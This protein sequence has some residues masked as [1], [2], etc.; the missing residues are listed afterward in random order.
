MRLEG[1]GRE[2]WRRVQAASWFHAKRKAAKG[3]RGRGKFARFLYTVP[4]LLY[5]LYCSGSMSP[6]LN[7]CPVNVRPFIGLY[8]AGAAICFLLGG[9]ELA[10]AQI[11]PASEASPPPVPAWHWAV[12]HPTGADLRSIACHADRFV[13]VGESGTIL[14]SDGAGSWRQAVSGTDETLWDVVWFNGRFIATTAEPWL[15]VSDDGLAWQRLDIPAGGNFQRVIANSQRV[16][17]AA[18][19]Q[20]AVSS[21]GKTW[22]VSDFP[23][24]DLPHLGF[25]GDRLVAVIGKR[26][27]ESKDC[28]SWHEMPKPEPLKCIIAADGD[29]ALVHV[30]KF[31]DHP[32]LAVKLPRRSPRTTPYGIVGGWQDGVKISTGVIVKN[33]GVTMLLSPDGRWLNGSYDGN[34]F[35]LNSMCWNG[36]V[37]VGVGDDGRMAT[38]DDGLSWISRATG[39]FN[40]DK[41]VAAPGA[42]TVAFSRSTVAIHSQKGPSQFGSLP[43]GNP[44]NAACWTGSHFVI[45]GNDGLLAHSTDGWHWTTIETPVD[46]INVVAWGSDYGLAFSA[47]GNLLRGNSPDHWVLM[48]ASGLEG[49]HSLIYRNGNWVAGDSRGRIHISRDSVIWRSLQTPTTST[50]A[51]IEEKDGRWIAVVKY[52]GLLASADGIE[53]M[54]CTLPPKTVVTSVAP[55][56]TGW[57]ALTANEDLLQSDSGTDWHPATQAP[58]DRLS[59]LTGSGPG[60]M[61][62]STVGNFLFTED[63]RHWTL[64]PGSYSANQFHACAFGRNTFVAVGNSMALFTSPDGVAWTPRSALGA[65]TLSDVTWTGREFIAAGSQGIVITSPDGQYWTRS[66]FGRDTPLIRVVSGN[67]DTALLFGNSGWNRVRSSRDSVWQ[68][69]R[70]PTDEP[71]LDAIW[72]GQRFIALDAGN[73]LLVSEDGETWTRHP[74]QLPTTLLRL[75]YA[76]ELK[77]TLAVGQ[78]RRLY[79]LEDVFTWS[80]LADSEKARAVASGNGVFAMVGGFASV[81]TSRDGK[82]WTKTPMAGIHLFLDIVFGNDRFVGVGHNSTIIYSDKVAKQR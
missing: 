15:L 2:L 47:D 40:W 37:L 33:S 30:P 22:S 10:R 49:V 1:A 64:V 74:Y 79:L 11:P 63:A 78:D 5:I 48:G 13:V 14:V 44:P 70:L 43:I 32:E 58:P 16:V 76:G 80:L 54:A 9:E 68:P 8:G 42:A 7:L 25:Q 38:S 69:L 82:S 52:G 72:S 73:G 65:L 24:K 29:S 59:S 23:T 61:A 51:Q 27:F 56:S 41:I 35:V 18:P 34:G 20:T 55:L 31:R 57:L 4:A 45:C 71:V 21:D 26:V 19:G 28:V 36:K 62:V 17:L 6:A 46:D 39:S 60:V 53:W 81:E 67:K 3:G 75:Q 12:P 77:S 66:D 50:L